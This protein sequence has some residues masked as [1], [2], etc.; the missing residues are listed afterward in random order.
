MGVSAPVGSRPA[1][2]PTASSAPGW[3]GR[4]AR[5]A[6]AG[7]AVL[8]VEVPGAWRTRVAVEQEVAARGWRLALSPADA[9][10]LVVCGRPGER[11][12]Q[13][14]DRTADQMP[15]PRARAEVPDV[16]GVRAALDG[17]VADLLDEDA[18]RAD[19]A[20]RPS[21][22]ED[23]EEGD[24]MHPAGLMLAMGD[25]D[26]RDG[27]EMDVL[28][29]PLGPVL[30]A[31]PAGLVLR[32]TLSGDVVVS[33]EPEVLEADETATRLTGPQDPA[34]ARA[35]ACDGAAR[36]L[37]LAGAAD[38]AAA[39]VRVRDALLAGAPDALDRRAGLRERVARSWTLRWMLRGLGVLDEA[40]LAEHGLPHALAG[41]VRDRLLALL[42]VDGLPAQ[43]P[44]AGAAGT[45]AEAGGAV[46][47]ALPALVTG[48]E[49]VTARLVVASL[50][51]RTE[52]AS[53]V[54]RAQ[55]AADD[56]SEDDDADGS[57]DADD[58]SEEDGEDG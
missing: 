54:V 41:D 53:R 36:L 8:L 2:A 26:L 28:P 24:D 44:D 39:A 21:V 35:R 40:A 25:D 55:P 30:P 58:D 31:W 23:V 13:V 16:A 45:Q 38:L 10:A 6:V 11:W 29:V 49:L 51:P 1:A 4:L 48:L 18:Q 37:A 15:G 33:A 32:C 22:P 19:A 47:A 52:V 5:R 20:A 7:V 9:D 12:Q 50:D 56:D 14:L 3:R 42:D 43:A 57:G 34:E 17:V 46:V 27:L